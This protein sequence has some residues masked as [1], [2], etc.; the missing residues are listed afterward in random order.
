[1]MKEVFLIAALA[2]PSDQR[3]REYRLLDEFIHRM[4]GDCEIVLVDKNPKTMPGYERLPIT[5]RGQTIY[6][7]EKRSA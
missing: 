2:L 4:R 7:R 6:I 3:S 5:Y 1:M